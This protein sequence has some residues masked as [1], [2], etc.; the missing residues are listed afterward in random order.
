M[1]KED[2]IPALISFT[3]IFNFLASM[4]QGIPRPADDKVDIADAG[5]FQTVQD[6]GSASNSMVLPPAFDLRTFGWLPAVK[7][8]GNCNSG[9]TFSTMAALEFERKKMGFADTNMSENNLKNCHGFNPGSCSGGNFKMATAYLARHSGPVSES[10]DPYSPTVQSCLSGLT[11]LEYITNIRYLTKNINTIKE[12]I[13]QQY[14]VL[15]SMYWSN[16]S[17]NA[18]DFTYYYSGTSATNHAVLLVGWNDDKVTAGGTGA[19]IARNSNGAVWGES[20]YFYISYNDSRVLSES[21][22]F[23]YDYRTPYHSNST[24]YY[25]DELGWIQSWGYETTEAY[26]LMK[27]IAANDNTLSSIGT[28]AVAADAFI[29]MEVYDQFTGGTLSGLLATTATQCNEPGYY[30]LTQLSNS[31]KLTPGNDYYIK[32]KYVTPG[33]NSP[34]PA[35]VVSPGYSTNAIIQTGKCWMSSD[36]ITWDAVG[37]GTPYMLDLCIKAYA[38]KSMM[39]P[40]LMYAAPMISPLRSVQLY[41]YP[42][43][44]QTGLT[45]YN[46]YRDG[47]LVNSSPLPVSQSIYYDHNVPYCEHVYQMTALYGTAESG[48][49]ESKTV[50]VGSQMLLRESFEHMWNIPNGW[51]IENI[52][53]P[54]GATLVTFTPLN[55]SC[56]AV[57]NAY[58]SSVM[59][60]FASCGTM[61]NER[62][63]LKRTIPVSTMGHS[64]VSVSFMWYQNSLASWAADGVDVQ[65]STNGTTWN[66]AGSILRYNAYTGWYEQ[67]I[68]L[69]AGAAG[70]PA[71]YIALLFKAANDNTADCLLDLVKI[72][73]CGPPLPGY[74]TI[75]NNGG[76]TSTYPYSTGS[77]DARTQIVFRQTDILGAGAYPGMI[78]KMGFFISMTP[79]PQVMNNFQIKMKNTSVTAPSAWINDGMTTVYSGD[80]QV[81][82]DPSGWQMITLQTPFLYDTTNLAV[83]IC[84][85]NTSYSF[86][87]PVA[88]GICC[89]PSV[90][91][92][93]FN[94]TALSGCNAT[95][96]SIYQNVPWFRIYMTP[97]V[98]PTNVVQ[99]VNIVSGQSECFDA[100][101]TISLAGDGSIFRVSSG[102]HAELVAGQNIQFFPGASVQSGGYLH[103]HITLNGQYC[104][105][106]KS[107]IVESQE[108]LNEEAEPG[109]F[110]PSG[111]FF[112]LW[113]NPTTGNFTIELI[114]CL[115]NN[116][117][118]V[119]IFGIMG[120]KVM[121]Q[122]IT[123]ADN[124]FFSLDG[125]S[126]GI[127]VVRLTSEKFSELIKVVK[128]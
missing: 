62:I 92:D 119:E 109:Q 18:S 4:G 98:T 31:V 8:Q 52:V 53:N 28:Y 112:H 70:Q 105:S 26:G 102:G 89:D 10:A 1:K 114:G 37:G 30:T 107:S 60:K 82:W 81:T 103:G 3:L 25:Y 90:L 72:N 121:S 44:D 93:R 46:L 41:F 65:W 73:C 7:D 94:G 20:G 123:G 23:P 75:G 29:T 55:P 58:D 68:N 38:Y 69:P 115:K 34:I 59:V 9:W 127:Y 50:A 86:D 120:E 85:D 76:G 88:K 111:R 63:R 74:I 16:S 108:N 21:G 36:G 48:F 13:Y 32:V 99:N 22:Y 17:Y 54:S 14:P 116:P 122:A 126:N 118:L 117:V 47:V 84:F 104:N 124:R 35:E 128:Q 42:P 110:T 106:F 71:L 12:T 27:F 113:P 40:Y 97:A 91:H 39:P 100:T 77:M 43:Y 101:Q 2:L 45:G 51:E 5:N 96:G 66:T 61:Q 67:T 19:W 49:S 57:N 78:T 11:P 33:Y 79:S 64:K 6:N 125:K 80:Y 87:T 83:Q 56:P 24:L 95:G 15:S